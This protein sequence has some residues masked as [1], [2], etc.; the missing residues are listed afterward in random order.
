M[1][2]VQK[3]TTNNGRHIYTFPVQA[4]PGLRTNIYI[5]NDGDSLI[6]VDTGSGMER[7]NEELL[8]GITAVSEQYNESISLP[9]LTHILITHG[10]I[11]HFGELIAANLDEIEQ[12]SHPV[13]QYQRA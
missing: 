4:F 1:N 3:F 2:Q 12:T 7:S 13:V 8:A 5:I 11:D 10:H 9:N 6:L